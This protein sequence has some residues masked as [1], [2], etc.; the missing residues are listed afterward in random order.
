MELRAFFC[1]ASHPLSTNLR[2][3]R[4]VSS[5]LIGLRR[6]HISKYSTTSAAYRQGFP[7]P[8][9]ATGCTQVSRYIAVGE[10]TSQSSRNSSPP[11][12]RRHAFG[13]TTGRPTRS[14]GWGEDQSVVIAG[15]NWFLRAINR[16][17]SPGS[18]PHPT[19]EEASTS[20][21][22]GG[23]VRTCQPID[24]PDIESDV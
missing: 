17:N 3:V 15:E 20:P 13:M 1:W 16:E 5:G 12:C 2:A 8:L 4:L 23:E 14:G 9:A 22:G 19:P 21:Q 24:F 11:L 18:S 10:Y 7:L 6:S